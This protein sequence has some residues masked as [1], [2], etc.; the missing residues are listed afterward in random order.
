MIRGDVYYITFKQPDKRRPALIL[1]RNSAISYLNS[2]T[3]ARN[4]AEK[5]ITHLSEV[6]NAGSF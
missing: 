5:Y 1:T 4:R 3:V 2:V 6:K